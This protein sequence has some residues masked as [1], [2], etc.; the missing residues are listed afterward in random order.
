MSDKLFL[1]RG[2]R[3]QDQLDARD[4]VVN[5]NKMLR[6]AHGLPDTFVE[7]RDD[8]NDLIL[9]FYRIDEAGFMDTMKGFGGKIAQ[10]GKKAMAKLKDTAPVTN[11][12]AKANQIVAKYKEKFGNGHPAVKAAEE[13]AQHADKNPERSSYVTTMLN[14][15]MSLFGRPD[16]EEA[17]TKALGDTKQAITQDIQQD[18][19][20]ETDVD[21]EREVGDAPVAANGVSSGSTKYPMLRQNIEQL[22]TKKRQYATDTVKVTKHEMIVSKPSGVLEIKAVIANNG[23]N[24]DTIIQFS[25]V[26]YEDEDTPKNITFT[27]S[28]NQEYN[29]PS[30]QLKE[31]N[32]KVRCNCLDFYHRFAQ[33]NAS[34]GSLQGKTP[35][36]YQPT[37]DRGSDNPKKLPG[38]CKHLIKTI[39]SLK[40][41]GLV[42]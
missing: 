37:T 6:E 20:V 18:D 27:A 40:Q 9:E 11:F 33:H 34:D 30:L 21:Q 3:I 28:D 8:I 42:S 4:K 26:K 41:S 12:S 16:A 25:G 31:K 36:P 38:V 14:G 5:E 17:V 2:S 10:L 24:Y 39:D 32:V 19:E 29:V 22:N 23:K 35:V 7:G 1:I 15:L 13:I